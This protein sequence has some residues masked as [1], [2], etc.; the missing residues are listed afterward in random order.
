MFLTSRCMPQK[1]NV[2]RARTVRKMRR[3]RR[4]RWREASGGEGAVEMSG[5]AD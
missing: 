5:W 2:P 4:R 3:R 1:R